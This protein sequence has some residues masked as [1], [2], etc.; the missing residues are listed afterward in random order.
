MVELEDIQAGKKRKESFDMVV[1]A[2]GMVPA[3]VL[4]SL[5]VNEAGFLNAVQQKGIYPAS[6]CKRPMDVSTSVKDATA[7]AL[8]S[9]RKDHE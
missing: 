2:T 7:T 3:K 8:K 4:P 6:S 9:M 5:S 1:L